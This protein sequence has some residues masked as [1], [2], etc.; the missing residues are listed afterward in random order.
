MTDAIHQ[1][2]APAGALFIISGVT[3]LVTLVLLEIQE[4]TNRQQLCS[5]AH[6]A[7]G[8]MWVTTLIG[9]TAVF[10]WYVL[11]YASTP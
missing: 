10:L 11:R 2:T 4:H 5:F 8:P 1:L 3:L 9:F 6:R 7:I